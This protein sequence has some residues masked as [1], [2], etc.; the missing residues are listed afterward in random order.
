MDIRK[1]LLIVVH[2]PGG[3]NFIAPAINALSRKYEIK[4]LCSNLSVKYFRNHSCTVPENTQIGRIITQFNPDVVLST[5]SWDQNS[6]DKI[7]IEY[8]KKYNIKTLSIIDYW[9]NYRERFSKDRK[10][11]QM[12]LLTEKIIVTDKYAYNECVALGFDPECLCI[13]GHPAYDKY[14]LEGIDNK[15]NSDNISLLYLSQPISEVYNSSKQLPQYPGYDEYDVFNII[16]QAMMILGSNENKIQLDIRLHPKEITGKY[17][18]N[19]EKSINYDS[20]NDLEQS[21]NSYDIII[22][23]SSASLIHAYAMGKPVICVH[24]VRDEK[25]KFILAKMG[26]VISV[27]NENELVSNLLSII[28]EGYIRDGDIKFISNGNSIEN[29]ISC[30]EQ[31]S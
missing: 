2:D 23:I 8:A 4:L 30:I 6:I 5:T 15:K 28:N 14:Y 26:K 29:I 31:L 11:T 20:F 18:K 25:H 21:L 22:G 10:S 7:A 9:S 17:L 1:K 13:T 16:Y 3:A 19:A 24:P 27:R 12:D